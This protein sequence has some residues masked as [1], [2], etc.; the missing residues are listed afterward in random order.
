MSDNALIICRIADADDVRE[1][2]YAFTASD[3]DRANGLAVRLAKANA[4]TV[5]T[6]WACNFGAASNEFIAALAATQI[7]GNAPAD[8]N[9][10]RVAS[11][12]SNFEARTP[13]DDGNPW[14]LNK[15][16]VRVGGN[17]NEGIAAAGL[18][19]VE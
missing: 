19:R 1:V 10:T 6:H 17:G 2:I 8:L 18:V 9:Q 11:A 4:P 16:H 14:N 12:I 15:I 13:D 3:E 7:P 5:H